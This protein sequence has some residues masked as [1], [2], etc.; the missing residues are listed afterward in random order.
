MK[1]IWFGEKPPVVM[2]FGLGIELR[3]QCQWI[4]HL[5]F[6]LFDDMLVIILFWSYFFSK[7][8]HYDK[9]LALEYCPDSYPSWCNSVKSS[10]FRCFFFL[11][12][13]KTCFGLTGHH[14]V[15]KLCLSELLCFPFDALGSSRC[16]IQAMLRHAFMSN[17]VSGLSAI[18]IR[19]Y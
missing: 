11:L 4:V 16:L 17:H 13:F 1:M 2:W 9:E 18:C 15:Y 6:V 14:Q 19:L 8:M 12:Y 3:L 7:L 10:R 5:S